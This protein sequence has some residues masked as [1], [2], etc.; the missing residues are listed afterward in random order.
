MINFC[1]LFDS[2]YLSRG[3]LMYESLVKHEPES[4]VYIVAFDERAFKIL[5]SL[6]LQK[7]TIIPLEEFEN[8]DL[9]SIKN[10]R[11]RA[12]YC[13]TCTSSVIEYIFS[14]YG[15]PSCTYLDADLFFYMS[16]RVLID[17][18]QD[19]KTVLITEHRFSML[20]RVFEQRRAGRFCVQFITF[21]NTPGSRAILK[22]WISQCIDWC[23]ARYEDGKFGDQKYLDTWPADYPEV[24][25][26]EN[27]G[28]GIA[29]WNARQYNF[30]KIENR[31]FGKVINETIR[32]NVVFFHFH[33]VRFMTNG[34]VDLGWNR[35][36]GAV[37]E[38]FY[39]NYIQEIINREKLLEE[40]Y[41]DYKM[42][43][44]TEKPSGIKESLKYFYKKL[45]KFN[46][47]KMPIWPI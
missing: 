2:R 9:L 27:H 18:L 40:V 35:I 22:K 47:V 36:P 16:P 6:K 37:T 1:T 32:F 3:L 4:W 44:Y 30:T 23:F 33:F 5:S 20:A 19:G 21:I 10:S 15:V 25:I 29:P 43:L 38:I 17:E 7:A 26:L 45:T 34:Y 46:I 41:P 39:K 13:W 24:H 31:I 14:R 11:S 8:A 12:E 42:T 28:G